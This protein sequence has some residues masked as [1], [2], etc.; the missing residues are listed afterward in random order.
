MTPDDADGLAQLPDPLPIEP[1]GGPIDATVHLPGS[2]SITNRALICA[3]LAE[4]TSIVKGA[5]FADDTM[6]MIGILESLTV[7]VDA[8]RASDAL[9]ISGTGGVVP[10]SGTVLDVRQSGTTARFALPLLALGDGDYQVTAHPQMQ[11]RPM[12][13]TI[14]AL[15][16]LGV[17][18][19]DAAHRGHL[20]IRATVASAPGRTHRLRVPGDASSQFLSGLLLI[21]PCLPGGLEIEL[22]TRLVSQPYVDMTIAVMEA[23]GAQVTRP[24]AQ[25]FTVAP[26][27]YQST[28]YGVEPDASAASYA[29]AAALVCGGTVRV[30]GL[31][32]SSLQG[33]TAFAGVLAALGASVTQTVDATVVHAQRGAIRGGSF[34]LTHLSDTAQTLAAIAPFA[35][36]P[37]QVTGIGFIR[38]KEIDRVAAVATELA[39]CGITVETGP[40]GWTI[41]PGQPH[42]ATIETS[43]DHR[44]AMSFALLGLGAP[45]IEIAGPACVAKTFPGFWHMLDGLR[46][47]H[48]GR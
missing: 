34:D 25:S 5:L 41:H 10:A 45:G 17:T 31:G 43:N 7:A 40:D 37:V 33:D 48:E 13:T 2:K 12:G 35:A 15:R 21:G 36:E 9:T 23:F 3:A 32:R 30:P 47:G 46:P 29:L 6:A 24:T 14:E 1:I 28:I 19:D 38:H 8:D 20:P 22:T 44:M 4:G 42:G 26:G 27:G 39:R 16:L 18:I 11:A